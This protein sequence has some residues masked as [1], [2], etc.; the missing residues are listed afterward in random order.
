MNKMSMHSPG[1]TELW[2][3]ADV[4]D[5]KEYCWP[6]YATPGIYCQ[7]EVFMVKPASPLHTQS[8]ADFVYQRLARI[9]FRQNRPEFL[10]L[11]S[12]FMKVALKCGDGRPED[13]L[14]WPDEE[15]PAIEEESEDAAFIH[16]VCNRSSIA[17]V[18]QMKLL[19][20]TICH[21]AVRW[22]LEENKPL[23]LGFATINAFPYR[24]NWK[25]IL[26]ARHPN[27]LRILDTENESVRRQIMASHNMDTSFKSEDLIALNKGGT[28]QWTLDITPSD[29]FFKTAEAGEQ[30]SLAEA[31]PKQSYIWRLSSIIAKKYEQALLSF[32]SFVRKASAPLARVDDSAGAN[33]ARL[34]P[35]ISRG[36][37]RASSAPPPVTKY[38]TD[39]H[40]P[41][42]E[43]LST[44]DADAQPFEDLQDLPD[45]KLC[46][47]FI[48]KRR[49]PDVR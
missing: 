25:A 21:N 14:K 48:A 29:E 38:Q 20:A 10:I 40:A 46:V 44:A 32:H 28:F 30:E 43:P 8:Q 13:W 26:H 7:D 5:G 42:H 36:R 4:K 31:K 15:A 49:K 12:K 9:S 23:N 2:R 3:I 33:N 16:Y 1:E 39:A 41:E 6:V 19:Y 27:S 45:G 18:N 11:R 34:V 35:R 47:G 37:V 22:L 17:D 24:A